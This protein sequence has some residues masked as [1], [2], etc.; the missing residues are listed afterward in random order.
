MYG[1]PA[2]GALGLGA[3]A[4]RGL[5]NPGAAADAVSA[6]VPKTGPIG[7][8]G[9]SITREAAP[10]VSEV[11]EQ[12]APSFSGLAEEA[13]EQ[14]VRAK[15]A[16]RPIPDKQGI[17]RKAGL[18]PPP[19]V[20]PDVERGEQLAGVVVPGLGRGGHPDWKGRGQPNAVRE[21]KVAPVVVRTKGTPTLEP[22]PGDPPR[23]MGNAAQKLEDLK[24]EGQHWRGFEDGRPDPRVAPDELLERVGKPK[25]RQAEEE[26]KRSKYVESLAKWSMPWWLNEVTSWL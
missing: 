20:I 11:V 18:R 22:P 13:A 25:N 5:R 9:A 4:Y 23:R 26:A 14:A 19:P 2:V 7:G 16:V 12:A 15:P 3:L 17:I 6:H 21:A 8:S 24:T 1:I 10:A